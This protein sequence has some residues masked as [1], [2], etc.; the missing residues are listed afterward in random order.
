MTREVPLAHRIEDL[1]TPVLQ[2][3]GC[4][5]LGWDVNQR[6]LQTIHCCHVPLNTPICI[7]SCI[8]LGIRCYVLT[9]IFI[10]A[11]VSF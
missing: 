4:V 2:D 6:I 1:L 3:P 5:R 9:E 7:S 8:R 11:C 10:I